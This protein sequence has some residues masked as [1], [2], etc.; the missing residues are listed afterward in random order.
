MPSRSLSWALGNLK[1]TS[2]AGKT[3]ITA[4]SHFTPLPQQ[5][6]QLARIQLETYRDRERRS[7]DESSNKR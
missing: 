5:Q 1:I 7:S 2:V 6:S 3:L 4:A